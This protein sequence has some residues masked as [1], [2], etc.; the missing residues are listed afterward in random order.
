MVTSRHLFAEVRRISMPLSG[1]GITRSICLWHIWL[2][3]KSSNI[4]II[5]FMQLSIFTLWSP[6]SYGD[7]TRR[8]ILPNS[9]PI[10]I[11]SNS[12]IVTSVIQHNGVGIV[13][14]SNPYWGSVNESWEALEQYREHLIIAGSHVLPLDHAIVQKKEH[15]WNEIRR[16]FSHPQAY[17][18]SKIILDTTHP[19]HQFRESKSTIGALEMIE[20]GD[21]AAICSAGAIRW[22]PLLREQYEVVQE[23]IS[24]ADNA[25]KFVVIATKESVSDVIHLPPSDIEILSVILSDQSGQLWE[26]TTLLGNLG[27]NIHEWDKAKTIP[28]V[29]PLYSLLLITSRLPRD[30]KSRELLA[31]IRTEKIPQKEELC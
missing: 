31:K 17:N 20:S 18:Q 22:N 13:P 24:P 29:S 16:I 28:G 19:G 10:F 9:T 11:P 27:V 7:Q 5:I 25:T 23:N 26:A 2:L 6:G 1:V 4:F 14:V 15:V 30:E 3:Q 8:Q 12:Q 21:D